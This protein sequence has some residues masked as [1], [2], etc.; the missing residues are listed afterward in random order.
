MHRTRTILSSFVVVASALGAM[1]CSSSSSSGGGTSTSAPVSFQADIVPIFQMSCETG[2]VCHGQPNNSS[3]ENLF[4]GE[5][6]GEDAGVLSAVYTSLVN[7]KSQEDPNMNLITPGSP[8]TSYLWQKMTNG[9]GAFASDCAN[10]MCNNE[11]TC[12]SATPCGTSM[13]YANNPLPDA[14]ATISEWIMQGAL[15]N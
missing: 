9:Q 13:P 14:A 12:T 4:L 5:V 15:N 1:G 2:S 10:G 11:P 8:S 7:V 3:E 6:A